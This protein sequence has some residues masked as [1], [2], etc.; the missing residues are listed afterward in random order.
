VVGASELRL[1]QVLADVPVKGGF[2][3]V[4]QSNFNTLKGTLLNTT[5]LDIERPFIWYDNMVYSARVDGA[6]IVVD[7]GSPH[8]LMADGVDAGGG[9]PGRYGSG[10]NGMYN[11][12]STPAGELALRR[13]LYNRYLNRL[14]LTNEEIYPGNYRGSR[15][16]SGQGDTN[17]SDVHLNLPP[18]LVAWAKV[19]P[20][21]TVDPESSIADRGGATIIV[22]DIDVNRK[23]AARRM[24][25][26]AAVTINE[27]NSSGRPGRPV[28]MNSNRRYAG[29]GF[30]WNGSL[31]V[32][33][34]IPTDA[35]QLNPGN[36]VITVTSGGPYAVVFRPKG[37]SADW[38]AKH[39]AGIG[40]NAYQGYGEQSRRYDLSEWRSYVEP[41]GGKIIGG[42]YLEAG[43]NSGPMEVTVTAKVLADEPA[44][45]NKDW[46][47]WQ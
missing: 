23:G 9:Y 20:L 6:S 11:S 16:M 38:S 12:P 5:G 31:D 29:T 13:S 47:P 4:L 44:T 41:G 37:A 10:P 22:A 32:E 24:W 33:I 18:L 2:E 43:N 15:Q 46:K 42:L 3:G 36:L 8:S 28:R 19:G 25:Y 1:V 34:V 40:N 39:L 7:E 35:L 17:K 14:F 21:G 45:T 26:D 30:N 27:T